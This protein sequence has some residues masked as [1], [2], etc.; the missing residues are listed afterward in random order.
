MSTRTYVRLISGAV[1]LATAI[2]ISLIDYMRKPCEP[3]PVPP[4]SVPVAAPPEEV[5]TDEQGEPCPVDETLQV[6][7]GDTLSSVLM[8]A[9]ID[10]G[11]AH[12]VIDALKEVFNPRDL[13]PDHE[14]YITYMPVKGGEVERD[15]LSLYIR[16]SIES[17]VTVERLENGRYK[18]RRDVKEL[19]HSTQIVKGEIKDSLFLDGAKQGVPAKILHEMIKLFAH[20][21]DFQRDFHPGDAYGLIYTT[22][23]DSDGLREKPGELSFAYLKLAGKEMRFYFFKPRK[24]GSPGFYD[25]QGSSLRKG[26]LRTPVDGAR[27]SSG[28]GTRKHPV[29]G[30]S[31]MHKGVDFAAPKGTPVMAAGDGVVEKIGPFSSYGNYIR[32][33]HNSE[34]STAYAHLS[35]FAAGLRPGKSVRQGQVIGYIGMTGRTTGPH[36]HYELIRFGKQVDP[37]HVKTM[38]SGKLA[39][40]DLNAFKVLVAQTNKRFDLY[41]MPPVATQDV[42]EDADEGSDEAVPAQEQ[43]MPTPQEIAKAS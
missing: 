10:A 24:G 13:R 6:L 25:L 22:A 20:V 38:P 5:C 40:A 31:K 30:Y 2:A 7:R 23:K 37:K 16:P 12:D 4:V 14:I 33:R 36:L 29:L 3:L 18:A 15:L 21:V 41:K 9:K 28:F 11:Q 8:R 19:I 43:D 1:C 34:I 39:G 42:R 27:L 26:L 32:L 35:R 17:E